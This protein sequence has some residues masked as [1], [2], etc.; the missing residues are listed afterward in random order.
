MADEG[1]A[2]VVEQ[3]HLFSRIGL[4]TPEFTVVV[5]ARER[6]VVAD[7]VGIERD[8]HHP[9]GV[10]ERAVVVVPATHHDGTVVPEGQAAGLVV[11]RRPVHLPEA[12]G[13][14]VGVEVVT[15]AG[16][17]VPV[18]RSHRRRRR[19]RQYR[20]QHTHGRKRPDP[21]Q[22]HRPSPCLS[23]CVLPLPHSLVPHSFTQHY[24][25]SFPPPRA[26]PALIERATSVANSSSV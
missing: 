12:V 1:V 9:H 15:K 18:G 23:A 21:L 26:K 6:T 10:V 20:R 24:P 4:A 25:T 2:A 3:Q 13:G 16:V 8:G 19:Q 22:P 17:Q 11:Q 7:T 14:A 5:R